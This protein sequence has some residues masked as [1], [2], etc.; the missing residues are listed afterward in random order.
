MS[1]KSFEHKFK[2]GTVVT[3]RSNTSYKQPL[4]ITEVRCNITS[5]SDYH[6]V[7]VTYLCRTLRLDLIVF[8]EIELEEVQKDE[9]ISDVVQTVI[10]EQL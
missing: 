4:I 5:P 2:V 8:S 9:V 1:Y 3:R 7:M 10:E 6:D